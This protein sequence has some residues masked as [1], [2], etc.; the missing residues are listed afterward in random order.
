MEKRIG[1]LLTQSFFEV[2][3]QEGGSLQKGREETRDVWKKVEA[4]QRK[5]IPLE[6]TVFACFFYFQSSLSTSE[7]PVYFSDCSPL[8]FSFI[9]LSN[10]GN[11]SSPP[12]SEKPTRLTLKFSREIALM[13]WR[14]LKFHRKCEISFLRGL[15]NDVIP[16]LYT[17]V[18]SKT[19]KHFFPETIITFERINI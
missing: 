3:E 5:N 7:K 4:A 10:F 2:F 12:R 14:P 9:R 8:R 18:F 13:P 16:D 6:E 15:G 19:K 17:Y 1:Y 11:E